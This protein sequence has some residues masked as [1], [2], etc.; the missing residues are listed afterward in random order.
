MSS[1]RYEKTG[2]VLP[3][4]W[5][6]LV[7]MANCRF[8][9]NEGMDDEITVYCSLFSITWTH[10]TIIINVLFPSFSHHFLQNQFLMRTIIRIMSWL[11]LFQLLCYRTPTIVIFLSGRVISVSLRWYRSAFFFC[12]EFSTWVTAITWFWSEIVYLNTTPFFPLP[13][14]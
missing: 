10:R 11:S 2:L 13:E 7:S 1:L 9:H 4:P 12:L 8:F 6:P 14:L 5:K 3:Q